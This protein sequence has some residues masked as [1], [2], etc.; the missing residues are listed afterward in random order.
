MMT[1]PYLPT[2]LRAIL[3]VVEN[4]LVPALTGDYVRHR[5]ELIQMVLLRLIADAESVQDQGY[6]TRLGAEVAMLAD[7][8]A[9]APAPL[10]EALRAV[11][12]GW[13]FSAAAVEHSTTAL[14]EALAATHRGSTDA[15]AAVEP[16]AV[17]DTVIAGLARAEHQT[18]QDIENRIL[19]NRERV[20]VNRTS[21]FELAISNDTLTRYLQRRFPDEPD[22]QATGITSVPGGRSKGTVLFD[23]V[24]GGRLTPMVI[25]KDFSK[26][27]MGCTVSDEY[28]IVRA[29]WQAGLPVPEPYWLES[30]AGILDGRFIVFA[31]VSGKAAGT[32][33]EPK[34][35]PAVVR[36]MAAVIAKLHALDIRKAG[37]TDTLEFADARFAV[38]AM[39][40]K[41]YQK[42]RARKSLDLLYEA[43]HAWLMKHLGCVRKNTALVHGDLALHNVLADGTRVTALLDWELAHAGD[44]AEDLLSFKALAETLIPWSEFMD[45]YVQHGGAPVSAERE[46]FFSIWKL[47]KY[48]LYASS[49][50]DMFESDVDGDLRLA[51]VGYNTY[52]RL[53]NNLAL[54]LSLPLPAN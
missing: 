38:G 16:P 12:K 45:L 53:Q 23:C 18:R 34:T 43:A 50:R 6:A 30:D 9:D 36:E 33:F 21:S 10:A 49:A 7:D 19:A 52:S 39:I 25:R 8:S 15:P 3:S 29:A 14:L 48:S 27:F 40:E 47:L 1:Q 13:D 44:P 51:A 28:P 37:L 5:A 11:R 26:D 46:R 35:T 32:M 42:H 4:D 22:I 17:L 2:Y 41:S 54:E 24:A 31:R 20:R